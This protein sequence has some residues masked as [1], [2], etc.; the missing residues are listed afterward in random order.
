MDRSPA[1]MEA[2]VAEG[3]EVG[4]EAED[5]SVVAARQAAEEKAWREA[6]VEQ[7]RFFNWVQHA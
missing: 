5:A 1:R 6:R 3:V 2:A 4:R 7:V